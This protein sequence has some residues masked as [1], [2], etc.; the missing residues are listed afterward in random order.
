[1]P[2]PS[3]PILA[4]IY[5]RVSTTGKGQDPENQLLQLREFCVKQAWQIHKI[6]VD[7]ESGKKGRRERGQFGQL[8]KDASQRRFDVVLFWSLDRF[9]RE[10][11]QKTIYYL[12]QLDTYGIRFKSYTE[13]MLDTDNELVAHILIG[14]LSYLA[15][16]E[17]VR[18]SE[19]T[20][21]GLERVRSQG[22]TLGRPDGFEQWREKLV[23]M[24]EAGYSQGKISRETNLSYNTVKAY[25]KRIES[26]AQMHPNNAIPAG[27]ASSARFTES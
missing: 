1:M 17:A 23:E 16:Q 24:K 14:V 6:Y 13:T 11:I 26:E 12:Q 21:A 3:K 15:K 10:G 4:A 7:Y 22:T 19:R 20:K 5:L 2:N 27:T 8:F 9:T 18:I 25:L